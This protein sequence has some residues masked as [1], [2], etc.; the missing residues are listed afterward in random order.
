MPSRREFLKACAAAG[1]FLPTAGVGRLAFA[2]DAPRQPLLVVVFQRGGCDG[3]NLVG[4]VNERAYIEARTSELRVLDSGERPG[5]ALANGLGTD[6]DFRLHPEAKPLFELYEARQMAVLHACGLANGTRSHFEAQDLIEHGVISVEAYARESA[7]WL[8][9]YLATLAPEGVGHVSA[10]SA[11]SGVAAALAHYPAALAVPDLQAGLPLPGGKE[12]AAVLEGLYRAGSSP[13]HQAGARTLASTALIDARLPRQPDGRLIPYG[14]AA[15][16][17]ENNG[18]TQGLQSIARLARMDLGL[19]VACIDHASW[20]THD[21]QPGRF[22]GLVGQLSRGLAAFCRDMAG[23]G[24]P[25]RIVVMTEFGRRLRSNRSQGTDHGHG[26]AMLVLGSGVAGGRMFGTWP[27]LD[28]PRLDQGVDLAVST[29][30]RQVLAE[31]LALDGP[32]REAVFP[33]FRPRASLGLLQG[34]AHGPGGEAA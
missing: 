7:G 31:V 4:P 27:G 21:A 11:N 6:L 33:G 19:R 34:A 29:D 8:T 9:R 3:L 16:G 10:V 23:A 1:V 17:Y 14:S 15:A 28:T 25:L 22:N 30:Y 20:D 5:L 13:V 12:A 2:A 32:A 18:F 24:Q 26:A